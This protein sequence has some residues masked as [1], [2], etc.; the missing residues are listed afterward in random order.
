MGGRIPVSAA[1]AMIP[2]SLRDAVIGKATAR[3]IRLLE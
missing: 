2:Q 1:E 3:E